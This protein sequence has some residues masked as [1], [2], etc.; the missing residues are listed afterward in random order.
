MLDAHIYGGDMHEL[1]YIHTKSTLFA[2]KLC[3]TSSPTHRGKAPAEIYLD[4]DN[5]R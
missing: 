5:Y 4:T 3:L 2:I 1:L